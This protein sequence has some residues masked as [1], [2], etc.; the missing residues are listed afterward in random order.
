MRLKAQRLTAALSGL[1]KP[2]P[3]NHEGLG[4]SVTLWQCAYLAQDAREDGIVRE[5]LKVCI[6]SKFYSEVQNFHSALRSL[7]APKRGAF[8]THGWS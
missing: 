2:R 4:V 5:K 8:Q 6:N 1:G 3:E 7:G